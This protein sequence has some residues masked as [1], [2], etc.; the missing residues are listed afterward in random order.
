MTKSRNLL[1]YRDRVSVEQATRTTARWYAENPPSQGFDTDT[2]I[3]AA[4]S[5]DYEE[6]ERILRAWLNAKE[7]LSDL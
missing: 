4:G 6:E 3:P 7:S 2:V 1:G 5:F